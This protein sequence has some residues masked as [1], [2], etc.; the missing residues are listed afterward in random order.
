[1]P[2][3]GQTIHRN[4]TYS[5]AERSPSVYIL[6]A[7]G[8]WPITPR[9]PGRCVPGEPGSTPQDGAGPARPPGCTGHLTELSADAYDAERPYYAHVMVS[10]IRPEACSDPISKSQWTSGLR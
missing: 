5:S 9:P 8:S 1:M 10:A 3:L 6:S 2:G 7:R 4:P